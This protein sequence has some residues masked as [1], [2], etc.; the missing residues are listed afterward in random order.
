MLELIATASLSSL[1]FGLFGVSWESVDEKIIDEFPQVESIST[2]ELFGMQSSQETLSIQLF[3]VREPEEY[4][5]SHL[6][7]SQNQ[8]KASAIAAAVRDKSTPIVVYCSV[9]YRSAAVAAELQDLGYSNVL[10]LH[11]S[12]FEWVEKG[13]PLRNEQGSA[14][15]VHPYNRAW[16]AL[17]DRSYH[18]FPN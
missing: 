10:N 2:D 9:G 8:S 7:G 14:Y 11:H 13:Y 18:F 12:I 3:D 4:A 1:L 5:V 17:I 16:G 6:E 15:K